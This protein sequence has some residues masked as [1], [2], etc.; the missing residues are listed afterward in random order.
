MPRHDNVS[1][2]SARLAEAERTVNRLQEENNRLLRE[3]NDVQALYKQ[4]TTESAHECFDERRVNLLKSQV[5]QLERQNT[6]LMDTISSRSEA[7]METENAIAATVNRCQSFVARKESI[8][9]VVVSSSDLN[10][11]ITT[12]ECAR[13]RLY[14]TAEK[15]SSVES[16]SKP[17][18]WYGSFLRN[19]PDPPVTLFDVCRG[20]IEHI[21]LKHVSR[22]ESKLVNLY[23]ELSLVSNT[24]PICIQSSSVGEVTPAAPLA[25]YS[26]LSDQVRH[27]CELLQDVCSQLLQLSLLVPAAPLP[28]LN[29]SPFELLTVEHLVKVFG[30]SA[31]TRDA[32]G[33]IEALVKYVNFSVNHA[34]I[35]NQLL[36]EEL[37]FHLGV[38][39][40]QT[41]YVESLFP[42][43]NKCYAEFQSDMQEVICKPLG[44]V[45]QVFDELSESASNQSLLRFIEIF[46][47]HAAGLSEAVQKLSVNA[48]S[49]NGEGCPLSDYGAE[50]LNRMK[51]CHYECKRKRDLNI[52]KLDT[53]KQQLSEQSKELIRIIGEKN[54]HLNGK[55]N[56]GPPDTQ[57]RYESASERRKSE[58]SDERKSR[59]FD[60]KCTCESWSVNTAADKLDDSATRSGDLKSSTMAVPSSISKTSYCSSVLPRTSVSSAKDRPPMYKEVVPKRMVSSLV[61]EPSRDNFSSIETGQTF[62]RP[63]SRDSCGRNASRRTITSSNTE[64]VLP[65]ASS[66]TEHKSDFADN[67]VANATD[68]RPRKK[69]G[70]TH[71]SSVK[72]SLGFH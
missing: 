16:S 67:A 43:M 45:L 72:S 27:V 14:R 66:L 29:K 22:L 40:L 12:L 8:G 49:E 46:R 18:L 24:L 19:R 31:K 3:L 36:L 32:K 51:A 6:M 57:T 25:V 42:C 48:C 68:R 70:R 53:V 65:F 61:D 39:E 9:E 30:K 1:S 33:L 59:P 13:K 26:R 11:I 47:S 44:E 28:A 50:F 60:G 15:A 71:A 69:S 54:Q 35:E 23:K 38:Y 20:D 34:G 7:L 37:K 55:D 17:L 58:L 2:N 52:A 41:H 62:S 5:I 21:N 56:S 64:D 10:Q 4:L 63:P